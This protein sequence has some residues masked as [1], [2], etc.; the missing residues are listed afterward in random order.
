VR[1]AAVTIGACFVVGLVVDVAQR[2]LRTPGPVRGAVSQ[3]SFRCNCVYIGLVVILYAV[4]GSPL[5]PGIE[6]NMTLAL[7]LIIPYL[8]ISSVVV[9]VQQDESGSRWAALG[10]TV[11]GVVTNPF[12]IACA[13]ATPFSLLDVQ[14]PG[15]VTRSG[16]ALGRMALPTALLGIGASLR[17]EPVKRHLGR[18]ALVAVLKLA[19]MPLLAWAAVRVVDLPPDEA[20][21]ILVFTACPTAVTAYVMADQMDADAELSAAAIVLTTVVSVVPLSLILAYA[22]PGG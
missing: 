18:A 3:A 4:E 10:K 19:A 20:F 6:R 9:L 7:G 8:S 22:V 16:E 5:A 17:W 21:V 11:R 12:V 14:L 15:F 1:V 13:L 2:L